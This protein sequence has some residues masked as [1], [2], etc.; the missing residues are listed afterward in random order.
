MQVVNHEAIDRDL[1]KMT[2]EQLKQTIHRLVDESIAVEETAIPKDAYQ[3]T[4]MG[5]IQ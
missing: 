4:T 5:F 3:G 1:N 2:I